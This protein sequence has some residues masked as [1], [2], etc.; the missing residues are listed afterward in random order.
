MNKSKYIGDPDGP[1]NQKFAILIRDGKQT[2]N[3]YNPSTHEKDPSVQSIYIVEIAKG[4]E[5]S[6]TEGPEVLWSEKCLLGHENLNKTL[7]KAESV[8]TDLQ[9]KAMPKENPTEKM[10]DEMGYS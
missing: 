5:W 6:R 3:V 9:E 10:L 8:V 4:H 2:V 1:E 7:L